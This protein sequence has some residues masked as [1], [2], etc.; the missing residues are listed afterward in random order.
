VEALAGLVADDD[1]ALTFAV[2]VNMAGGATV[3]STVSDAQARV[4]EVLASWPRSP[5]PMVLGP[6]AGGG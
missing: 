2:V 5:D 4:A 1:P 3:P 6:Q